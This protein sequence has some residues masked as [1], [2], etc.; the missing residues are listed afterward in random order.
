MTTPSGIKLLTTIIVTVFTSMHPVF[1]Q[2]NYAVTAVTVIPMNT[3]SVIQNQTVLIRNGSIEKIGSF[4]KTIIPPDYIK[5]EGKGKFLMPGLFDMHAHFFQEQ[6]DDHNNTNDKELKMMLANGLTTARIMAGH[7]DYL[8]ARKNVATGKWV[9]PSLIVASPQLVGRWPWPGEF[10]N[11]EVIDTKEKGTDAVKKFK[12]DGYDAIK[13]TF[14]V[15]REAYDAVVAA[16]KE[17]EI[18][19]VGHVGPLVTLPVAL[20][21]TEQVEHMDE[22]IDMLLPDTS[23]NH[24]QSVSDMN[25]WRKAAW[26][27]VPFLDEAKLPALVKM[28]K[29]AGIYVTPTNYFFISSFGITSSEEE[30]KQKIDY[31]YIPKSLIS[32]R[33]KNRQHW[34]DLAIPEESRNKYVKLRKKMVYELWKAGVPLM[35][36]SDSPEF[37]L[38]TGFSLHNEL[39]Q[40]VDAGLTPFAALQTATINPATYLGLK[41]K[42]TIETGKIADMLLLD[43]DPLT[44]IENTRAINGVFKNGVWYNREALDTMLDDAKA[45]SD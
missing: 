2:G 22:F 41:D 29:N 12:R 20:A 35:A 45:L 28:V 4:E 1:S 11:Y 14:M 31:K 5:V 15:K 18:K 23:Y 30:I 9:G 38:V 13:L 24:G 3:E 44:N 37:F 33:W 21:A 8:E 19:V 25:I 16:A 27:T 43:K 26:S 17:E 39:Q 36:G 10:K 32:G 7:P 6:Y 34:M 42:G 40:F